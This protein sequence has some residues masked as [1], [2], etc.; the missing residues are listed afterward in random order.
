VKNIQRQAQ[1]TNSAFLFY[2]LAPARSYLWVLT[3]DVVKTVA[4]P[5][6]RAIAQD[7]ASYLSLV[8]DE[9]R[10]PLSSANGVA[11][12]LYQTL[13]GPVEA[14]IPSGAQVVVVPDGAL[15]SLNFEML[16]SDRPQAHYWIQDALVSVAPSLSILQSAGLAAEP[17]HALLLGNPEPA[18]GYPAL[19]YAALELAN[20]ERHFPAGR[21]VVY[22][23]WA[24][25]VDSYRA[26]E[27]RNFSAIHFAAHAE[28]NPQSPLDSAIILSPQANLYKLYARDLAD[29]HINA[30]LVT[31]SACRGAGAR[32]Y[33]GEGL[34]GFAWAFFQAG[35]RN[36]VAGLWDVND[37]T[38]AELMNN[39]YERI[40]AGEPY[41][42]ALRTAKL[43]MLETARKPYYWAPFQL[44]SRVAGPAGRAH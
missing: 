38:T 33:S 36:V 24:A 25:T 7:V 23:R 15:H 1:L 43:R 19:P 2:W 34:V 42:S 13:I 28:A 40:A 31:I 39:F 4:L 9:K 29:I 5:D 12:R 32:A 17:D 8:V 27:P 30:D 11:N 22:Q 6:E 16:I 10:D 21:T 26:A 41:A 3:A 14:Y 35:A 20:I 44:Y 18:P 37:S